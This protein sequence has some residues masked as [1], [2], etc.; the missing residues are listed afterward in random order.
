MGDNSSLQHVCHVQIGVKD[1]CPL[2]DGSSRLLY[3][4][5]LCRKAY[6]VYVI[7]F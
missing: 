4:S 5:T 6:L 2:L 3:C 7:K 1:R